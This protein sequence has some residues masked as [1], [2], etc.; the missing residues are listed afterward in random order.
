[1]TQA[2][3]KTLDQTRG[4]DDEQHQ[5]RWDMVWNDPACQL[6][7]RADDDDY[8]LWNHDFF[9]ADIDVLRHIAELVGAK[10]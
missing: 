10:A 1:M 5:E 7:K 6:F 4:R 9:N 2:I 8:W 3:M